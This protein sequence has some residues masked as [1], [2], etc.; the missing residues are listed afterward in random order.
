MGFD[1]RQL[2][3]VRYS[4]VGL[5]L[6][7]SIVLGLFGGQWLDEKLGSGPWLTLI[8]MLFGVAT[9]FRFVYRAAKSMNR[10]AAA[11]E[12]RDADVGRDA[13]FVGRRPERAPGPRTASVDPA[14][15]APAVQAHTTKELQAH[16]TK[17]EARDDDA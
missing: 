13:R 4:V 14:A 6:A 17:A 12:F 3:S 7:I 8:G 5:E 11:D 1:Q 2:S 10:E 16:T 9:G 15:A